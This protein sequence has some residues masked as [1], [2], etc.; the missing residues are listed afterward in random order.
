MFLVIKGLILLLKTLLHLIEF[1]PNF[2]YRRIQLFNYILCLIFRDSCSKNCDISVG[3][4]GSEKCG[5][6]E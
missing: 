3:Y 1:N 2:T 6:D 5:E 4:Y